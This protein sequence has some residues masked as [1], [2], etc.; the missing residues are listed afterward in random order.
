MNYSTTA[1]PVFS[2]ELKTRAKPLNSKAVNFKSSAAEWKMPCDGQV[3]K[4]V[5]KLLPSLS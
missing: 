5:Q 2:R 1:S 3:L 4:T